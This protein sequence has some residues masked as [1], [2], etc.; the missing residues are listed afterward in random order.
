MLQPKLKK[1]HRQ[2]YCLVKLI[3]VL[4][5]SQHLFIGVCENVTAS[6]YEDVKS[7]ILSRKAVQM[8]TPPG[9]PGSIVDVIVD[10]VPFTVL[11]IDD[12]QQVWIVY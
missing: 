10:V 7:E 4:T 2:R 11:D 9:Q 5:I 8:K 6:T 3:F 12:A 1:M